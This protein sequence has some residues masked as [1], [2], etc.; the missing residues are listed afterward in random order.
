MNDI[1]LLTKKFRI[2]IKHFRN[3]KGIAQTV[4]AEKLNISTRGYQRIESGHSLPTLDLILK[5]MKIFEVEFSELFSYRNNNDTF[6]E[7]SIAEVQSYESGRHFVETI[8]KIKDKYL[9]PSLKLN[10]CILEALAQEPTFVSSPLSL[11]SSDLVYTIVNNSCSKI[12]MRNPGVKINSGSKWKEPTDTISIINRIYG[13]E[14]VFFK[15]SHVYDVSNKKIKVDY[16]SYYDYLS[17]G[18][19]LLIGYIESF[20]EL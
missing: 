5:L 17:N 13:K 12:L 1:D 4:I 15:S 20:K 14:E 6:K 8:E 11:Y 19:N 3:A 16:C 2:N 10:S 18:E 9:H 7:Y